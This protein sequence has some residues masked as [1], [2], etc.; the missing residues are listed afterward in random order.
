MGVPHSMRIEHWQSVGPMM[1]D[2]FV[3]AVELMQVVAIVARGPIFYT[4]SF[5]EGWQG[6]EHASKSTD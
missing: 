5:N 2:I 1:T 3:H 4:T 6:T